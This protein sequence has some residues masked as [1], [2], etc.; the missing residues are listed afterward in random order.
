MTSLLSTSQRWSRFITLIGRSVA[1][2]IN[3]VSVQ[4]GAQLLLWRRMTNDAVVST[5][6]LQHQAGKVGTLAM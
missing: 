6:G 4:M 1:M 3:A 5:S 2:V